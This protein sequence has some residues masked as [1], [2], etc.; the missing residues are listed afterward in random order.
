MDS[1]FF[2][3][4]VFFVITLL[5]YLALKPKFKIEYLNDIGK[6][7]SY[8]NTNYMVLCI[9]FLAVVLSQIGINA[10]IVINKCG[11]SV[12]QN[13]GI[14]FFITFIPWIFIFG[15]LIIVL[16]I[17]PGFKLAFSNFI[18]YFAVAGTANNILTE[19]LVNTELNNI[20]DEKT[21]GNEQKNKDLKSAA[22]AI[23]KVCGNMSILINQIVPENFQDYWAMITPLMK[24][25]YQSGAPELKQKLL[26]VV[27]LKDNIGEA[28]WYIYTAILLVSITQYSIISRGCVKDLATQQANQEQYL[29]EQAAVQTA[30]AKAQ[31]T[32][33]T[34]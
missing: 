26:D 11:G 29:T 23:I 19:L 27:V 3:L 5:Y 8:T 4:I 33:Y 10:G 17:F 9:Y 12:T 2:S 15:I 20:I 16:L 22:E 32:I 6:L 30:N 7:T 24:D 13:F 14:A 1:S 18:G 34:S 28:M 25:Q 31:S 21:E